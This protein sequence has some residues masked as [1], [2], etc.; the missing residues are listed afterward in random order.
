MPTQC[1]LPLSA[2]N[3][4]KNTLS[5]IPVPL[6]DRMEI[7][8]LSGYT[9][10]EKM[11]IAVKYLVPRQRKECGLDEVPFTLSENAI[12]TIVHHY[13]R[14]AGVRSLERQLAAIVRGV[15]VKIA[16]GGP[17][18]SLDVALEPGNPQVVWAATSSVG[19]GHKL[20]HVNSPFVADDPTL[21]EL[22]ARACGT[23]RQTP[24]GP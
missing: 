16:E 17:V 12:R 15:A 4:G 24:S 10:F 19:C 13:T 3:L 14:E 1:R 5:G 22:P 9:E 7:I 23:G 11:N 20:C 21:G 2:Y 18:P 6:Q 8:Q